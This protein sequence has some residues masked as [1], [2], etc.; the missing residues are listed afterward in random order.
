[1]TGI[2]TTAGT[3]RSYILDEFLPGEDPA[4]LTDTTEL[5]TG[6]IIDSLATLKLVS[7]LE[8]EFRVSIQPHEANRDHLNTIEDIT[9]LVE[10]KRR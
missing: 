4:E 7:F 8:D 2:A 5:V 3:I 6:G 10:S 9:R 1:M